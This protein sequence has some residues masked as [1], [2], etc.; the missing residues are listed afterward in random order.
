MSGVDLRNISLEALHNE[1]KR[2]FE[3][4]FKPR[5]RVVLGGPA[6]SGKGTQAPKLSQENC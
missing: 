1:V 6:G 4:N 3:C 5:G 2:R